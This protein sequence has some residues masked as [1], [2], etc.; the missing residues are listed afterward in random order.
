MN[1]SL[2]KLPG[3]IGTAIITLLNAFWLY[4][5]LGES[6]YEGWGVPETPWFLFLSIAAEA[7]LF[8][9]LAIRFPYLGGGILVVAG[10]AF[11][12]WW[13]VPG[14]I[15]DL[16]SLSTVLERL[17]LSACFTLVGILFILDGCFNPK[18]EERQKSWVIKNLRV[19]IAI[20]VPL[21]IG[22]TVAADNLPI[23]LTRIDDGD[24]S[25]RLIEGY[26]I[27]LTW[28]PEGP[29]WNWKQAFGGYPS[30]DS[31]AS[32]GITPL[33]LDNKKLSGSHAAEAD[34]RATGLCA[35]L[36]TSGK[37]LMTEPQHIWRMPTVDEIAGALSLHNE[38]AG[39]QWDRGVG[40]LDCILNPDKETPLWAPDE[41]PVYYW[42]ADAYNDEN[43]YYVSYSGYVRYQPKD[44]GNPRHGYRYV[45]PPN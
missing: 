7:M 45:K 3:W 30:W 35:Y 15:E 10:L 18:S 28:A 5:G 4:W 14:I 6:F 26:E 16:Y 21:L 41:P 24:R 20:G 38:N 44:W 29:G 2:R 8:T 39:C 43:A 42:S 12:I 37:N 19:I 11:A 17:F 34:M 32:Y 25:A 9:L 36:D 40:R 31:L 33:G 23:V 1:K 27:T 22:L 13:L